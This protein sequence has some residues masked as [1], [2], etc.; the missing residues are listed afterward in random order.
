MPKI[1]HTRPKKEDAAAAE[2]AL[3]EVALLL[4]PPPCISMMFFSKFWRAMT[5]PEKKGSAWRINRVKLLPL[6]SEWIG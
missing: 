5:G 6:S 1:L 2:N 4:K 3:P